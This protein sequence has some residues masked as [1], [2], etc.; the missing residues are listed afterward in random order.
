MNPIKCPNC[1]NLL[2]VEESNQYL[3]C[4]KCG[5]RYVNPYYKETPAETPSNKTSNSPV[6]RDCPNCK[7]SIAVDISN[8]YLECGSCGKRYRN[9]YYV[10]KETT[11]VAEQPQVVQENTTKI[12]TSAQENTRQDNTSNATNINR[13]EKTKS[14]G[15]IKMKCANCG[16]TDPTTLWEEN[17]NIYCS[18][19]YHLTTA[20]NTNAAVDV[21]TTA[22]DN[23]YDYLMKLI[24]SKYS[25]KTNSHAPKR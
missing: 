1:G 14:Y 23:G 22:K 5:K 6:Y 25:Q 19:C 11:G 8:P 4:D 10:E 12:E 15:G 24:E 20:A 17:G 18:E 9:P 21:T 3:S 13:C 7:A 16:N 2:V